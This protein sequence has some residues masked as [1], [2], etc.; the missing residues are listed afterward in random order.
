MDF[1]DSPKIAS[2]R[3]TAR[4]F[5]EKELIPMEQAIRDKGFKAM[6]PELQKKRALAKETGLYAAPL[7][8][9]YGGAGLKLTEVAHLAEELARTPFGLYAFN[10][11]AP[12]VGNME[13]LLE[14]GTAEQKKRYL[15]PLVRGDIRSCFS[16]TEPEH[17]GSNPVWLGTTAKK[18][19]D[20]WVIRGHKWFTSSH[21]GSAFAICMAVTN[22]DAPPH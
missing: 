14:H 10:F 11:Q 6:L 5:V 8:E 7:P 15:E 16:M 17:P 3:K 4:T 20:S 9:A 19:G 2:I 1:T 21:D 22:P 18:D 12:D 13:V